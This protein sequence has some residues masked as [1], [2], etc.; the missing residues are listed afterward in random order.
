MNKKKMYK[1]DNKEMNVQCPFCDNKNMVTVADS[2]EW[3][4]ICP[5]CNLQIISNYELAS[6]HCSLI[7]IG[8]VCLQWPMIY[9]SFLIG[10]I[11]GKCYI[12]EFVNG[13]CKGYNL[14]TEDY[15]RFTKSF[16]QNELVEFKKISQN[17]IRL[18]KEGRFSFVCDGSYSS[19]GVYW[20]NNKCVEFGWDSSLISESATSR[21]KEIIK[22]PQYNKS[23]LISHVLFTYVSDDIKRSTTAADNLFF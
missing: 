22:E 2:N 23:I 21:L 3:D 7:V 1:D 6:R 18:K 4:V 19:I 16:L 13:E 17:E 8:D 9:S 11:N 15:Y 5:S 14:S 20:D 10:I 12:E